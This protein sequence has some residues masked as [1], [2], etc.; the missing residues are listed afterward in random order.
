VFL[1]DAQ[2][3]LDLSG[4]HVGGRDKGGIIRG[5]T[6][7][8]TRTF[9]LGGESPEKEKPGRVIADLLAIAPTT[10]RDDQ[11]VPGTTRAQY[12]FTDPDETSGQI[13]GRVVDHILKDGTKFT[14]KIIVDVNLHAGPFVAR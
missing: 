12:L 11:S 1:N 13:G 10:F 7:K 14:V 3:F 4:R 5:T 2:H 8:D 6:F 9:V